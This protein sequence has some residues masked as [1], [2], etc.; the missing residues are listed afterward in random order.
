MI[1]FYKNFKERLLFFLVN[2]IDI[3]ILKTFIFHKYIFQNLK[4]M[5][6][7]SMFPESL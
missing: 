5:R 4:L 3:W 2:L 6:V 7:L 1:I